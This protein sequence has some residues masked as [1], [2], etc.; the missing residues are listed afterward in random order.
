MRRDP[1]VWAIVAVGVFVVLWSLWWASGLGDTAVSNRFVGAAAVPSG[2]IVVLVAMRIRRAERLDPRTRRAWSIIAVALVGY[3]LG[4]L[5]HLVTGPDATLSAFWPVGLAL[6]VATY[7]MVVAA[8]ALIPKPARTNFDLVLFS[9]N[10]T[11]VAFSAAILIWHFFIYPAARDAGQG[12]LAAFDAEMCPVADLSL[13]FAIGAMVI[14][15]LREEAAAPRRALRGSPSSSCS[16]AISF[17]GSKPSRASIRRVGSP[18]SAIPSPGS[19]W[20]LPRI[21]ADSR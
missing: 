19:G 7:P 9:L 2:L 18:A 10:V 14:R 11:I 12:L 13:V 21:Y 6:E 17:R 15:G 8:L 5:V 20:Q 4:A 3:G 16:P 1:I